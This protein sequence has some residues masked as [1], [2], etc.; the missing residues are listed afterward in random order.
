VVASGNLANKNVKK[1]AL[2]GTVTSP[3]NAPSALTVGAVN[4]NG[5]S[6][7]TDDFVADFSG[8]G[9]SRFD[10]YMKPDVVAPG[11]AIMSKVP[12]DSTLAKKYPTLMDASGYM[13]LNG[14]S[15]A[16][17][18]VV[19]EVALILS[20]NPGLSAHT[21]EAVVQYTAQRLNALDV[22]TQGAGEVNMAG[23]V[24]LA[25]LIN[26]TAAPNTNW[27]KTYAKPTRADL[28]DG[29]VAAWG[30]ATIW[31]QNVHVGQ[32]I[33][34]NL[35]QWDDKIVWGFTADNIV[36]G[37]LDNAVWAFSDNIVWGF[38]DNI[39][40]GFTDDNIVWGYT[41]ESLV[42]AFDDNIVW[43]FD[44]NIVWGFDDNIVWGFSDDNIVWGFDDNIVWGFS[45]DIAAF[46]DLVGG[47]L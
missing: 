19:G 42:T 43:G 35:P 15:M 24:R 44:D 47:V 10:R 18:V 25:K 8:R 3:G 23:A 39:V 16:T 4:T 45:D 1:Q 28:L 41:D 21:V 9:P 11:Y 40:W 33:Y 29:E 5:T 26:P 13:R 7:R 31:G 36:W 46:S 14:T 37:Y 30:R 17:P 22:M 20:A 27:L 38:E 6:G 34:M 12:G 2:Y 32:N